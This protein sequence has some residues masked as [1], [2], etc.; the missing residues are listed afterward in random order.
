MN[1]FFVRTAAERDL[2]EISRLLGETWHATYDTIYGHERV[3]TI[4][5]SWHDEEA[6]RQRLTRPS[7]EFLVA[8][9]GQT[10][11]AMAFA[12]MSGATRTAILHQLYVLSLWQRRGI[13]SDLLAEVEGCFPAADRLRVEVEEAN[14]AAMAFYEGRGFVVVGET[15]VT[16]AD[17]APMSARVLEKPIG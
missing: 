9:D 2:A 12:A 17:A 5:A 10:I 1:G 4:T 6:L 11:A 15:S 3:S 13:G 8:D 16:A 14:L 7:S